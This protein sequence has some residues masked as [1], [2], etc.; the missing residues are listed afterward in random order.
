MTSHESAPSHEPRTLPRLISVNEAAGVLGVSRRQVYA[1]VQA[2]KLK[3][4]KVGARLRFRLAD[5]EEGTG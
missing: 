3:P 2:G 4:I 5:L 1:L